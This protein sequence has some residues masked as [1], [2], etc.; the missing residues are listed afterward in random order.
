MSKKKDGT[1]LKD[2]ID[3]ISLTNDKKGIKNE[4]KPKQPKIKTQTLEL[5]KNG[6][7]IHVVI[8][9]TVDVEFETTA[10]QQCSTQKTDQKFIRLLKGRIYY[11][12]IK[13]EGIDSDEYSNLKIYSSSAVKIDVRYVKEG[14][15]CIVPLQHGV[16]LKNNEHI[17]SIF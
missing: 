4:G 16:I 8:E 7:A 9:D 5:Q 12:P 15:A 2:K 17:C 3:S 1:N 11:I 10:T 13:E 6:S 14:K